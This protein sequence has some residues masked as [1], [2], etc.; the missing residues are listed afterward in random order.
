VLLAGLPVP[1]RLVGDLVRSLRALGLDGTAETLETARGQGRTV[2]PLTSGDQKAILDAL[3]GCPYGLSE[4]RAVMLLEHRWRPSPS[5][6]GPV[7]A[8]IL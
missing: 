2:V 7:A 3:A 5:F 4:L 8:P 1:D 6:V